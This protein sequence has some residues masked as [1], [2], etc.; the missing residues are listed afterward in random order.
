MESVTPEQAAEA[1]AL[2][3]I[4]SIRRTGIDAAI[5]AQLDEIEEPDIAGSWKMS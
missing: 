2:E 4:G 3:T 1:E 5:D